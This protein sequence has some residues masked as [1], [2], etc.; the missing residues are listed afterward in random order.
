MRACGGRS[1]VSEEIIEV[2]VVKAEVG[3][4]KRGWGEVVVLRGGVLDCGWGGD[5]CGCGDGRQ[6]DTLR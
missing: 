6:G 5:G 4:V 1:I 3:Y 2:E